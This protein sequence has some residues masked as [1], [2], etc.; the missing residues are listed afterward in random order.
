MTVEK[1]IRILGYIVYCILWSP[2]TAVLLPVVTIVWLV[3]FA[4]MGFTAKE[5]MALY[6]KTIKTS[7]QHDIVFIK[8]GIWY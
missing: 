7:I 1:F 2:I 4:R 8:T 5:T 6:L 3:A